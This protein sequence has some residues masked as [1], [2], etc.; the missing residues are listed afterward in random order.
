MMVRPW[1]VAAIS[2]GTLAAWTPATPARRSGT[3]WS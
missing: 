3:A 1:M 2:L